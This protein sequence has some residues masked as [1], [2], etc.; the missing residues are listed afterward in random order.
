V[1]KLKCLVIGH[2]WTY[3]NESRERGRVFTRIYVER[4]CKRCDKAEWW[5][6]SDAHPIGE[7]MRLIH[8]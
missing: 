6:E 4:W 7:W 5:Y 8:D 2:F 1:K 3:S